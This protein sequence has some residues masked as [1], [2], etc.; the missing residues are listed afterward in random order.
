MKDRSDGMISDNLAGL[1]HHTSV[2]RKARLMDSRSTT[3]KR[4]RP[5]SSYFDSPSNTKPIEASDYFSLKGD[6]INHLQINDEHE[7]K[8]EDSHEFTSP[9]VNRKPFR[10]L[11]N[12]VS[13]LEFTSMKKKLAS[14]K[15]SLTRS[16]TLVA[17]YSNKE[18]EKNISR[19]DEV[20]KKLQNE[21]DDD[22][23]NEPN[24]IGGSP[25]QMVSRN[26][27]IRRIHSMCQTTKEKE[28][29][30]MEDNSHLPK[31]TINTFKVD[32]DLLPRI[33]EDELYRILNGD[34][35]EEFDEYVV[36]DCRFNYE[37]EGGHIMNAINITSQQGLEEKF[38]KNNT[39]D[40]SKR[41]LYIFH[42]EFSIFRSPTMA[43]HLRKCDRI[44]NSNNYPKLT[45]PD[46]VVLEGGYKGFYDKYKSHCYPQAYVEMKDVN[47]QKT[48]ELE[49]G[50]VRQAKKLPRAKSY[51]HFLGNNPLS[52]T[53]NRS[54]SFTTITS[55]AQN[56]KILKRQRSTSKFNL[57]NNDTD[58]EISIPGTQNLLDNRLTRASTF[59]YTPSIFNSSPANSPNIMSNRGIES[60]FQPPPA[61]FKLGGHQKSFSN[62]SNFSSSSISINSSSSSICSDL[63]F[64]STD[65]LT[66]SYSSPVGEMPEFFEAKGHNLTSYLKMNANNSSYNHLNA[67]RPSLINPISRKPSGPIPQLPAQQRNIVSSSSSNASTT[68]D[69]TI[70]HQNSKNLPNS[71]FKFPLS[72]NS[73]N[74]ASRNLSRINT[75]TKYLSNSLANISAVPTAASSPIMNSPLSTATPISTIDS[76]K[77]HLSI[78]DPINDTPVDFSVPS[79]AKKPFHPRRRSGSI[80]SS[81]GGIHKFLDLD[82]DEVEEEE[83]EIIED[84]DRTL[85]DIKLNNKISDFIQKSPFN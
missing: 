72:S 56:L 13:N 51:N 7:D 12:F 84:N 85:T 31:T 57:T 53:H 3:T 66:D 40:S 33:N 8:D 39:N 54:N 20:E 2:S 28:T 36:I 42:C 29:Y 52:N 6:G 74:K 25:T 27:S 10:N 59:T 83:E 78:I 82:I 77:S 18:L 32:N 4:D 21:L 49:M 19:E 1:D 63:A 22:T 55:H 50:K 70:V 37:Y 79:S 44:L 45:Y 17:K 30:N 43:S 14:S 61:L 15:K 73:K 76:S 34:Y 9:L 62:S 65:S 67:N 24:I 11:S 58:N 64:S 68:S 35:K 69:T 60:D 71:S 5:L 75:N 26:R 81:G 80:L 23:N 16:M 48:C 38:I 41:R 46:I 47:H